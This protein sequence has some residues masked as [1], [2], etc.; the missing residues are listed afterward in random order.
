MSPQSLSLLIIVVLVLAP[1][2]SG[3]PS[4]RV[5]TNGWPVCEQHGAP[6]MPEDMR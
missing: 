1:L 4:C 5:L 6:L 3:A 2:A